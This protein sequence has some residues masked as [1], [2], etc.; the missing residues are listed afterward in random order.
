MSFL[1]EQ[2]V[3]NGGS[4]SPSTLGR[5]IASK[6]IFDFI[7]NDSIA[8]V[9]VS[10]SPQQSGSG[11][12]VG[13]TFDILVAGSPGE[14]F[15]AVGV[16]TEIDYGSTLS[17]TG[18]VTGVKI[19][20]GGAYANAVQS[21]EI[22]SVGLATANASA[23]GDDALLVDVVFEEA[24]WTEDRGFGAASPNA[25]TD[26]VNE[27]TNFE[28]ICTSLKASNPATIGMKTG[29]SGGNGYAR[30][31]VATGFDKGSLWNGQPGRN[32]TS[33][34]GESVIP[35][36]ANNPQIYVSSSERR[37]NVVIRDGA[38]SHYG[39]LGFFIPYTNTEANYPFPGM[40]AGTSVGA[41]AFNSIRAD[42]SGSPSSVASGVVNAMQLQNAT[43]AGCP[44]HY[45]DNLSPSW[46]TICDATSEQSALIAQMWPNQGNLTEYDFTHAPEVNGYSTDP[47]TAAGATQAGV[48][49]DVG[50]TGWFQAANGGS[51]GVPGIAPLGLQNRASIVVQP[52]II[53]NQTADV[54]AIGILDGFEA[55]HGRGLTAFEEIVQFNGKRY[56]A[57]NDVNSGDLW[58]W[59]AMEIV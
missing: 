44:Y 35:M 54:Q 45:R 55:V 52:H 30:L 56:I 28:W 19:V 47:N 7:T 38:F 3:A 48:F 17:P 59:V 57:F 26:Y 15:T 43:F 58:R 46:F 40:V 41:V 12:V 13:E 36:P 6:A 24:H 10:G 14:I 31:L 37:V 2:L 33:G 23:G 27:S 34:N 25:S 8:S 50:G 42:N 32:P 21:P 5:I 16:V 11:Y 29:D 53:K 39:I 4:G 22:G 18:Q 49:A 1:V 51:I 20:S 9:S